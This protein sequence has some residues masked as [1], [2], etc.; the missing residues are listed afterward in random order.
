MPLT[1]LEPK[2]RR[3]VKKKHVLTAAEF[4]ALR[5]LL[6]IADNRISAAR[7]A[8]VDDVGL[9]TIASTFGFNN[10]Q[11]VNIAVSDVMKVYQR[12]QESIKV[13]T[14]QKLPAGWELMIVAVPTDAAPEIRKGVNRM[15]EAIEEP[16][17]EKKPSRKREKSKA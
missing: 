17:T 5:P 3:G 16:T 8:L 12:W 7:M 2:P 13:L 11:A 14:G 9:E 15:I 10:R 4:D 1:D 6:K